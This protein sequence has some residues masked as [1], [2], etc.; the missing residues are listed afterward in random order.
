M[1]RIEVVGR[2]V[3]LVSMDPHF[4][5]ISI[6][7]NRLDS[8]DG[9]AY[10]VHTYSGRDGAGARIASVVAAM[11]TMGD[12]EAVPG[13][14]RLLRFPCR[15]AHQFAC[16]RLF[17]EAC[18]IAPGTAADAKPLAVLDRKSAHT[19]CGESLG[20]GAYRFGIEGGGADGAERAAVVARGLVKLAQM[21]A[22]DDQLYRAAFACGQ[23]H[24][25]L[26]GLLMGRALNVRAALREVEAQATRG[27]LMAPSAQSR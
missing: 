26:I 2:R 19:I 22:D 11:T 8:D 6:A 25:A 16:R 23:A 21:D 18:K 27:V 14:A 4:H 9:C 5:D 12:M 7:L 3:E 13:D 24:D 10:L 20:G 1:G 17:L 15:A